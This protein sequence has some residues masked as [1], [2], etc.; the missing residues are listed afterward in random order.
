MHFAIDV[1][2]LRGNVVAHDFVS[3]DSGTMPDRDITQENRPGA[4]H[5]VVFQSW[6][7][8]DLF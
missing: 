4:N 5:H 2:R 3:S 8:L 1:N 6:M 7:A